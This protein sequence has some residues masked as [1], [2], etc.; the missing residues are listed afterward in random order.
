M[1]VLKVLGIGVGVLIA[2]IGGYLAYAI[3]IA[4]PAVVEDLRTNPTGERAK[5]V[6]ILS[7]PNGK[8]LPVN[9][10]RE[11]NRVYAGADGTWWKELRGEGAEV[12]MLI[13]GESLR[14]QARAVEGDP[15]YTLDIFK[16]LRPT[17]YK[18]LDG[19]LIE[20]KISAPNS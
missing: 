18:Y 16:R 8:D 4:N 13:Q 10:L 6:M 19:V 20:I 1:K 7:L 5:I 15:D 11:G 9:Y 3:L 12:E 17:S 2:A 14:G